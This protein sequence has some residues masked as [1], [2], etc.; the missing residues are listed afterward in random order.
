MAISI[1]YD[2]LSDFD[3][4]CSDEI[5]SVLAKYMGILTSQLNQI[6]TKMLVK[7]SFETYIS[8]EQYDR[9]VKLLSKHV[10]KL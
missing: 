9:K 8:Q 3:D 1:A 7:L 2:Y 6:K 4:G 10:K 5:N